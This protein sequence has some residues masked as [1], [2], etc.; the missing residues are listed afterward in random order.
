MQKPLTQFP[1]SVSQTSKVSFSFGPSFFTKTE[2][3]NVINCITNWI[4]S[5]VLNMQSMELESSGQR[6]VWDFRECVAWK[7][8]SLHMG[9]V[10]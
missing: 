2:Q 5:D 9:Y 4:V 6:T 3:L 10:S 1:V 7:S 8:K